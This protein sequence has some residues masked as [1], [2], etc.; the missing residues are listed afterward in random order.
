MAKA[1]GGPAFPV[2]WDMDGATVAMPG[3]T[4]RDWFA[5]QALAGW[6]ASSP[7]NERHPVVTGQDDVVAGHAYA[8]ADAMLAA[9]EVSDG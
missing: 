3:M 9:R 7:G 2:S 1:D 5:G 4:L 6:L 8:M